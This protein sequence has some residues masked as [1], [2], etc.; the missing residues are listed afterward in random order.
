MSWT[1]A[2]FMLQCRRSWEGTRERQAAE[3]NASMGN[4]TT[5]TP[6]INA[7]MQPL[8]TNNIPSW[9]VEYATQDRVRQENAR[10]Q[11]QRHEAVWRDLEANRRESPSIGGTV[12]LLLLFGYTLGFVG[13]GTIGYLAVSAFR[14]GIGV[15]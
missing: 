8:P 14:R 7:Q 9:Q 6:Q 3:R 10:W 12:S 4:R 11:R 13:I 15:G 1:A 2:V 5:L